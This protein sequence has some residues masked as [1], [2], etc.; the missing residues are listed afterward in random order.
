MVTL[1]PEILAS[2]K[3]GSFSNIWQ[4]AHGTI[5]KLA[6]PFFLIP[7]EKEVGIV[8]YACPHR[9]IGLSVCRCMSGVSQHLSNAE[10]LCGR[11]YQGKFKKHL[12]SAHMIVTV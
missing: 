1:Y 10:H 8:K 12:I 9:Y 5:Q 6:F 7:D 2:I 11:E 4:K 3:H